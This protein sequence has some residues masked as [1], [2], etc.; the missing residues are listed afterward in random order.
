M[1]HVLGAELSYLVVKLG[2]N[3]L[4]GCETGVKINL[5]HDIAHI[6]YNA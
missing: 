1:Y 4:A 5:G 2:R 3:S 6:P